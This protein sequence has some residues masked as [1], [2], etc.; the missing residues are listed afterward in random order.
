MDKGETL[1]RIKAVEAQ[2][3]RS[4]EEATAERDKMLRAARREVLELRDALRTEAERQ[5]EAILRAAE[6]TIAVEKE[7][8]LAAGRRDAA[9]LQAKAATN[10]ARAVERLIDKFKGA[11]HA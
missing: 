4:K 9:A 2:V 11:S 1:H 7:R 10:A 6:S 3:R 8:V 5:G